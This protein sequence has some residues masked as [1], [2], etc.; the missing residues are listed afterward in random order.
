MNRWFGTPAD[1]VRQASQRDQRA[2]RRLIKQLTTVASDEEHFADC[3][4]SFQ[5]STKG[6]M[7]VKMTA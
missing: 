2:A 5:P 6:E 1:S 4:T 7:K 3:N